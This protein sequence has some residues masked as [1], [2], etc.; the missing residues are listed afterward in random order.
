MSWR[1]PLNQQRS[2][3]QASLLEVEVGGPNGGP[4]RNHLQDLQEDNKIPDEWQ[5]SETILLHK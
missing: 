4:P 5:E 3:L 1:T 2:V